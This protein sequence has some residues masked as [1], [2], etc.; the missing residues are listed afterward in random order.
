MCSDAAAQMGAGVS[1]IRVAPGPAWPRAEWSRVETVC[2]V[3]PGRKVG[4]VCFLFFS[5][6]QANQTSRMSIGHG[7]GPACSQAWKL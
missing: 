4:P 7:S 6:V 2:I 5:A 3:F 1:A